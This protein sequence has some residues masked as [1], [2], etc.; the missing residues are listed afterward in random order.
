MIKI[1]FKNTVKL[2]TLRLGGRSRCLALVIQSQYRIQQLRDMK[3][4]WNVIAYHLGISVSTLRIALNQINAQKS[5]KKHTKSNPTL[6]K[7]TLYF[8]DEKEKRHFIH[9]L[10][11]IQNTEWSR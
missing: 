8:S 4:S 3:M 5:A 7:L 6:P 1:I 10:R 9:C 11:T 2:K